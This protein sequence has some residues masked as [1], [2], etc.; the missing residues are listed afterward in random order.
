[1]HWITVMSQ[2]ITAAANDLR[3]AQARVNLELMLRAQLQ[4]RKKESR[5]I[6]QS[7]KSYPI[8]YSIIIST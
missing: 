8:V 7:V 6:K 3:P 4:S 1:M 5:L 2:N